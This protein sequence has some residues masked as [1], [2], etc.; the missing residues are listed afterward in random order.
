M[1]DTITAPAAWASALVNNDWSSLGGDP[2]DLAACRD[3]V[4]Q[5]RSEGR[6]V[7]DTARDADGNGMDPWFAWGASLY[8]LP[9]DGCEVLDY[10]V[11]PLSGLESAI[12]PIG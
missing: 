6:R 12:H 10:I 9:Y 2:A 11:A 8:G 1:T 7:V 5:L 3:F 4:A